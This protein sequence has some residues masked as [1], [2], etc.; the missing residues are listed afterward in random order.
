MT[1]KQNADMALCHYDI[2]NSAVSSD[3]AKTQVT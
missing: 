3:D 1:G 2:S